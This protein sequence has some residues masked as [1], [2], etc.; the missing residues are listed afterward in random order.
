MIVSLHGTISYKSSE[1]RKD[2]HVVIVVSGVGYKV[3]VPL[4]TL[5]RLREEEEVTLHTHFAVS[6]HSQ[7]LY[8]FLDPAD[9]TFFSLLLDVQGVGPKSALGILNKTTM[10][11][12]QQ[13]IFNNDPSVLTKI[14]GLGAKTAEKIIMSLKDKVA[15]F[16]SSG[17]S[18]VSSGET[19][20]FDA[21]VGF[22]YSAAE[23]K[24]ALAAISETTTDTS[25]KIR[26][27]LKLLGQKK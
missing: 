27:A 13:A 9:K 20:V 11:E 4:T 7:D 19:D 26:E 5:Q 12:V 24:H 23:A 3:F 15:G 8:G 22:G 14:S 1:L 25:E 18:S 2:A 21:L 10:A 17:T 16:V 6:E